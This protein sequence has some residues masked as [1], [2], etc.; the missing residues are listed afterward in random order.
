MENANLKYKSRV[1]RKS[2]FHII[3][4]L[5]IMLVTYYLD[6][7]YSFLMLTTKC[8]LSVLIMGIIINSRKKKREYIYFIGI[9][10]IVVN[11]YEFIKVIYGGENIFSYE[12][13]IGAVLI[14][15]VVFWIA[16]NYLCDKNIINKNIHKYIVASIIIILAM[17][18]RPNIINIAVFMNLTLLLYV[19]IQNKVNILEYSKNDFNSLKIIIF[20]RTIYFVC[21]FLYGYIGMHIQIFKILSDTINII[22][23]YL[24]YKIIIYKEIINP[25]LEIYENNEKIKQQNTVESNANT[26]LSKMKDLQNGINKKLIYKEQLYQSILD[27]TPNGIVIFDKYGDIKEFNR[28][29]EKLLNYTGNIEMDLENIINS[30]QFIE[31][32]I[33]V[34]ANGEGLECEIET[35]EGKVYK[36]SY[37]INIKEEG[38]VCNLLDITKEKKILNQLIEAKEE[39][40]DLIVNIKSAV[41]IFDEYDNVINYAKSYGEFLDQLDMYKGSI[42]EK[43]KIKDECKYKIFDEDV[44]SLKRANIINKKANNNEELFNNGY[45]KYRVVDCLGNILWVESRTKVYYD[46][47]K[48]Y[49]MKSYSDITE[50]INT[51]ESLEKSKNLYISLLDSVPE[52]IYLEDL[53]D[54]RYAFVNKKFKSIFN[55]DDEIN[56]LGLCRQDLMKVHPKYK[57]VP[58]ESVNKI[59]DNSISQYQRIKYINIEGKTIDARTASIPFVLH[60][61]TYK[62]TIINDMDDVKYLENLR[63]KIKDRIRID[64]MKMEFFV[65]MSH[66]LKT[67]LNL[68]FTSTQLIESLQNQQKIQDPDQ[69]ISKHI[70]LTKQNSYRLLKIISD[71]IDFTKVESGCYNLRME[72]KNVISLIE[73]IVMSV[74]TY[75]KSKG[76]S[77]IFDTEDEEL[78]MDVDINSIERILLNLLSNAIKF[79]EAGGNIYVRLT[80]DENKLNIEI[81]DTGI[82]IKEDKI[83]LIFERFNDVNSGFVG[84]TYGSGIGLSMVKSMVNIIGGDINVESI[85]GEGT[86]FTVSLNIDNIEDK[87]SYNYKQYD[88]SN[89]T[90]IERLVVDM[91]D[92]YS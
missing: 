78:I 39:Y 11:I 28:A 92:I 2:I 76:I 44:E 31:N 38:C 14:E 6:I 20:L 64:K 50:Y 72:S 80:R 61:K 85:Y 68:I 29:F 33:N 15:L 5:L 47:D 8:A 7:S 23:I 36:S 71:L 19:Y 17:G 58:I 12:L 42:N 90:N 45:M 67:P 13:I 24:F 22:Q 81:E 51:K 49:I 41:Y 30:K 34:C 52:A 56:E 91:S 26:I 73:D 57:N 84:N 37:Y 88:N 46:N 16:I 40:E 18:Y 48:K 77:V 89:S 54:N 59:K 87:K 9:G 82:G 21:I 69:R 53:D 62:L 70:H 27:S 65:N 1:D 55:I 63:K 43:I 86:K 3:F 83:N 75:A 66:E 4:I 60:D 10:Y 25:Y 32:A 35:K 79:T 74:V